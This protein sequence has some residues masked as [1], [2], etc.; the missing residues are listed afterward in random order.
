MAVSP[1]LSEVMELRPVS[2]SDYPETAAAAAAGLEDRRQ[3]PADGSARVTPGP[4]VTW[5]SPRITFKLCFPLLMCSCPYFHESV[6]S[7]PVLL[8]T[9]PSSGTHAVRFI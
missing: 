9:V 1:S 5:V 6:S 4:P 8:L 3:T 2:V 7:H